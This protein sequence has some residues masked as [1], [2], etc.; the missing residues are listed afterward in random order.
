MTQKM[1][2]GKIMIEENEIASRV[3]EL[4][5]RI[6]EEYRGKELIIIGV[7]KGCF[8]F[9]SD[10]VRKLDCDARVYFMEISSYSSGTVSKGTITIKK[11]LDV[12]IEGKDVLIAED[13]IDSG[14]TLSQLI[15]ILKQRK[16]N[17]IKV[18]A[19]LSKPSRRQVEFEADYTGF[20]IEDKFIIGYGLD[21]DERFRQLPY[22][23]EVEFV[24]E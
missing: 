22:I 11:D 21:C 4:A 12:D 1:K 23:A 2:I 6:S 24:E 10:L 13:I 7:L 9:I 3:E 14:N 15:P 16:P 17:S 8:V 19:L 5:M 20:V 18:C